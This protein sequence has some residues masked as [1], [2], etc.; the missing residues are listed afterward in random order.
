MKPSKTSRLDRIFKQ[1]G[2]NTPPPIDAK[3]EKAKIGHRKENDC[4]KICFTSQSLCNQAMRW[5]LNKRC[6]T[7]QMRSYFCETCKSW[8]MT[9]SIH[10][11]KR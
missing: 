9:S 5:R 1:I 11:T 4:G 8:H 10:K 3:P 7:S 2:Y 6:N